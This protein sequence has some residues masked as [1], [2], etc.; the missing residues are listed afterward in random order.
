VN[1]YLLHLESEPGGQDHQLGIEGKAVD[2]L[3]AEDL[4]RHIGSPQLQAALGVAEGYVGKLAK[5]EVENVPCH[6]PVPGRVHLDHGFGQPP[7]GDD[8]VGIGAHRS[9]K[10]LH[11]I[12]SRA[13]VGVEAADN[14]PVHVVHS[15]PHCGPL[16]AVG[17]LDQAHL[18][19][20][21][22]FLRP[23]SDQ[24]GSAIAAA[25]VG[26]DDLDLPAGPFRERPKLLQ[27][28]REPLGL[29]EGGYYERKIG[30]HVSECPMG[31]AKALRLAHRRIHAA[32]APIKTR[33]GSEAVVGRLA[34]SVD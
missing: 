10:E 7:G 32:A 19:S 14:A 9:Q 12:D 16:A 18:E 6:F 23:S 30:F 26:H 24:A 4:P 13:E 22:A 2:P 27:R 31:A 33:S 8:H 29:V 15:L 1:R 5:Q 20:R 17:D 34:N 25:V 21:T 28:S 11:G 3:V